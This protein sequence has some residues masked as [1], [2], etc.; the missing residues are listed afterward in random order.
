[1]ILEQIHT[2]T[3]SSA[4]LKVLLARARAPGQ[5]FEC[6]R[7][8]YW[9]FFGSSPPIAH[10]GPSF[11]LEEFIEDNLTRSFHKIGPRFFCMVIAYRGRASVIEAADALTKALTEEKRHT[12]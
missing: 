4:E 2:G 5:W 9:Y 12:G 10:T 8:D 1:M 11:A 3:A 6:R 7:E